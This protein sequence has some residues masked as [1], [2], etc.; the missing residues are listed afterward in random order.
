[1]PIYEYSCPACN[2]E[3]EILVR[4][5]GDIPSVCPECRKGKPV[6][7]F[8][9]FA[10]MAGGSSAL[11]ACAESCASA[12]NACRGGCPGANCGL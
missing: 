5:D 12:S 2:A 4:K 8:S 11:P 10:A 7:A 6:K 9:S 1:M 3:F